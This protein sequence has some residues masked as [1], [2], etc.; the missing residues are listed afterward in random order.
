MLHDALR[1]HRSRSCVTPRYPV[2][3][4]KIKPLEIHQE[5]ILFIKY[6]FS[7][8]LHGLF[9]QN[10]IKLFR[11]INDVSIHT[12]FM[13]HG[14]E[15]HRRTQNKDIHPTHF[16]LLFNDI[17]SNHATSLGHGRAGAGRYF[18]NSALV[19]CQFAVA[20]SLLLF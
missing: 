17:F 18:Q 20:I 13:T 10:I 2:A 6:L 14:A 5:P 4:N 12:V 1:I 9:R 11:K 16:S 3:K 8:I 7:T 19:G 15:F